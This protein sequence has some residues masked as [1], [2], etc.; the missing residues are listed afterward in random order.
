MYIYMERHGDIDKDR[1]IER[2]CRGTSVDDQVRRGGV[3]VCGD[4]VGR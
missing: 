4:V 3:Q 1:E 2:D